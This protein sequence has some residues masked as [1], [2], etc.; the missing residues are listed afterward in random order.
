[1]I[2]F[3]FSAFQY[4]HGGAAR[5]IHGQ[6]LCTSISSGRSFDKS[7][8]N[9]AVITSY[10]RTLLGLVYLQF[11]RLQFRPLHTNPELIK[12]IYVYNYRRSTANEMRQE[13]MVFFTFSA[14]QY[15]LGGAARRIHGQ[16]LCTSI[17]SGRS[18]DKSPPNKAVI[19]S[20]RRTLLGRL[21]PKGGLDFSLQEVDPMRIWLDGWEVHGL[22]PRPVQL[23]LRI[24]RCL[25]TRVITVLYITMVL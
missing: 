15:I 18:Y 11:A 7:S 3:I 19:T 1:M 12:Q 14:F 23:F 10:R 4:I 13:P 2:F 25:C 24:K 20:Y 21:L 8:P 22:I 6:Q 17:S 9:K 16:Q 5:R